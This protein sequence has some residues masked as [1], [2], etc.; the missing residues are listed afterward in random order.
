MSWLD[1]LRLLNAFICLG[2]LW[3]MAMKAFHQWSTWSRKTQSHWWAFFGWIFLGLEGSLESYLLDAKP[4]PRIVMATVVM[5]W[6][7]ITLVQ[8]GE[9]RF[10]SED[11]CRDL[12]SHKEKRSDAVQ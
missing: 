8:K 6:T 5:L 2:A 1:M 4:G 9:V 10:H 3:Y 7:V 12:S 11:V